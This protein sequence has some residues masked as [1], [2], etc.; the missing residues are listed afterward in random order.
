MSELKSYDLVDIQDY[1][2]EVYPKAE[3]DRVITKLEEKTKQYKVLYQEKCRD[4][5]NQERLF[6]EQLYHHKYKR[7]LAMASKCRLRARWFGDNA[8][9]K[10]EQ[11]ALQWHKRWLKIAK[12]FKEQK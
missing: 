5:N 1:H 12:K 7:C 8:F 11:R 4:I 10:K 9:Y 2:G 6:A 3:A